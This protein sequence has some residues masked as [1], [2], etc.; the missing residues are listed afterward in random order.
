LAER[1]I[2]YLAIGHVT[3][4]LTPGGPRLGGTASFAA[5][6]ARALEYAPGVVTACGADLDLSPLDGIPLARTASSDST[7]FENIYSAAGRQQYLRAQAAPLTAQSIP[8]A[9]LGARLAHLG[10]MDQEI[11]ADVLPALG[12]MFVGV[13][14]QGWLREW[15]AAGQVRTDIDNWTGAAMMLSRANAVVLSLEDIGRDWAVAER[16]AKLAAVVVVTEGP[17]GCTVFARGQGARQFGVQQEP[18]VDPTGAGDIFAAAF[19]VSL[20]ETEDPWA[21]ARFANQVAALSVTRV[22]LAGVPTAEEVGLCRMR[23]GQG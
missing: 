2:H 13:T 22:G 12:S 10:P 20:Y 16:W 11:A 15:D 23:A 8:A 6:T 5:L 3:K 4:D 21:S 18:E 14:P 9:W 1:P 19:F 7:T 17:D